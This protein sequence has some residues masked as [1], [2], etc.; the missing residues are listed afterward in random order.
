M[1]S[2]GVGLLYLA[3]GLSLSGIILGVTGLRRNRDS[4][5][6]LSRWATSLS[7]LAIT[8]A[9]G[10]LVRAF[11]IND[12]TF[13]YVVRNSKRSLP[14]VYKIS[15]LWAG[16][17]GSLLLW[18]MILSIIVLILHLN[19]SY[20]AQKQDVKLAIVVNV[21]R[22]LFT[23]LLIFVTSPFETSAVI[24]RDGDGL[25]PMLQSLGMVVHPPILFMG[26]SGFLIPF[27]FVVI[28]LLERD[29][30]T[31]WLK[32]TRPWVL[33]AWTTLT[34]GIVTGGQWAYTELGWGGYWAWDPVENA[35]LF[36]WLTS[37]ALLHSLLMPKERKKTKMWSFFL[38]AVTFLLT[39]F[40][41]FLTRSGVLDSVHAFSSGV[42][43]HIFLAVLGI[44]TL[45]SA[46]LGISRADILK[47]SEPAGDLGVSQW[48]SKW[49]GILVGNVIFLLIFAGVF[50]GTLFPL[51]SRTFLGREIILGESFY[52]QVS[53]PLF[54]MLILIMGISPV[55]DWQATSPRHFLRRIWPGALF[56]FGIG[57]VLF[58]V[59]SKH[60]LASWA[61]GLGA[62]A[63]FTH[64]HDLFGCCNP[65]KAGAY[66]VHI[67]IIIMLL[68]ITGSSLFV[69]DVFQTVIPGE[70]VSIGRYT[71]QY[72]GLNVQW[73]I[74][75]YKVG[76]TLE[77]FDGERRIGQI[78]STKTFYEDQ[79]QPSTRVG[80]SSNL[81]EDLYFHL[82]GWQQQTA[83]LHIQRFP[84]VI[85]IWIGSFMVYLGMVLIMVSVLAAKR[86]KRVRRVDHV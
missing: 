40:G 69:E 60:T 59:G 10:I 22:V 12:F 66:I 51:F 71:M 33:F 58:L 27:A 32:Q 48:F 14:L 26:F 17:S 30:T 13:A 6:N 80:I 15:A 84:L 78:T 47:D 73:G 16:Q 63:L 65:R 61:F 25:N 82:A 34:A 81:R 37:T 11:M 9:A 7:S 70:T 53:V 38:I 43:G 86:T 55:C 21:V 1:T 31:S 74:Y 39:I 41:T 64:I 77:I 54:L 29:H 52:N 36:P 42:L 20:C 62:F 5:I 8:G 18:L 76:T 85:W 2:F 19:K 57:L 28:G 23:L 4:Q 67:G 79:P 46:Y 49:T 75:S 44:T 45:F 24:P 35:S 83:Q 3:L 50:L 72:S 56:G 68:G